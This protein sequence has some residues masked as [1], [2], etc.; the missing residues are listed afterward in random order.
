MTD[1]EF[2]EFKYIKSCL[3]NKNKNIIANNINIDINS[4]W[5]LGFVEGEGTFGYKYIVPY[6]QIAHN[7]RDKNL[8]ESINM[9]L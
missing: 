8:L 5:L 7:M 2:Q 4:N 1:I 9:F 3:S 6:F